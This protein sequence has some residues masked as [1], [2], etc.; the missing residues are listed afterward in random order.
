MSS[1]TSSF[2]GSGVSVEHFIETRSDPLTEH[3]EDPLKG[4]GDMTGLISK[5]GLRH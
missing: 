3:V 1:G 5:F 4:Q 2:L